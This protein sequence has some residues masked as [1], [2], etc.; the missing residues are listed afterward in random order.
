MWAAERVEGVPGKGY[1]WRWRVLFPVGEVA[2]IA[3][4]NSR[5]GI[6]SRGARPSSEHVDG[7]LEDGLGL[8]AKGDG[9]DEGGDG[10]AAVLEAGQ[11]GVETGA[12]AKQVHR[13]HPI[14]C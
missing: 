9:H 8:L 3:G 1:K 7:G 11:A 6:G 2:H 10:E 12:P 14:S 4:G 5:G 13:H